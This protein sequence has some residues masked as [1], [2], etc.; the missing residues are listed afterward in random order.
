MQKTQP[1]TLPGIKHCHWFILLL[2]LVT[3]TMQFSLDRKRW[4]LKQNQ[5]LIFTRSYR[6]MPLTT[7]PSLVKTSLNRI[8]VEV[9][10]NLGKLWEHSPIG[11]CP[12]N[13]SHFTKL[14]C[15]FL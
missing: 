8:T 1:I 9:W 3:P 13:I 5:C 12:H 11:L 10:E 14:P 7:T 4:R 2:L 15:V 6:S